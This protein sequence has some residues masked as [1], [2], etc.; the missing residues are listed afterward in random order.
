MAEADVGSV[1]KLL[2]LQPGRQRVPW[3]RRGIGAKM[4][5]R[6]LTRDMLGRKWMEDYDGGDAAVGDRVQS[7][8]A[9]EEKSLFGG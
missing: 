5:R 9:H 8:G 1:F 2:F 4:F 6:T 7:G 3:C